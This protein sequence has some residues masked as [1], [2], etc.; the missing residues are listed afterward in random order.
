MPDLFQHPCIRLL[1]ARIRARVICDGRQPFRPICTALN[2]TVQ[3]QKGIA[4]PQ[5]APGEQILRRDHRAQLI[6]V[7]IAHFLR[8]AQQTLERHILFGQTARRVDRLRRQRVLRHRADLHPIRPVRLQRPQRAGLARQPALNAGQAL[9]LLPNARALH[10]HH[11]QRPPAAALVH[12]RANFLQRQ[13]HLLE[14]Q[15]VI[16]RLQLLGGI[17]PVAVGRIDGAR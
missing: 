9:H 5:T 8:P 4:G 16:Q 2:R 14:H 6:V 17:I 15:D 1:R 10:L 11:L 3:R 7:R 13:P 12:K